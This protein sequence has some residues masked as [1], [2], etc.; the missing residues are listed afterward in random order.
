MA[1]PEVERDRLESIVET[2]VGQ[3]LAIL[4]ELQAAID[5]RGEQGG[6]F[7]AKRT[8]GLASR[9]LIQRASAQGVRG[10]TTAA[11]VEA[12]HEELRDGVV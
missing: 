5:R 7:A 3:V 12:G 4:V 10:H 8:V 9:V 11:V 2:D 6:R 1:R